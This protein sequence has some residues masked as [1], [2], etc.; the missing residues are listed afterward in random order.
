MPSATLQGL[1]RNWDDSR[2]CCVVQKKQEG[3]FKSSLSW[4]NCRTG[5]FH[6][7]VVQVAG[8]GWSITTMD[9]QLNRQ[10]RHHIIL[11]PTQPSS[12]WNNENTDHY[13]KLK[14]TPLIQWGLW[15]EVVPWRVECVGSSLVGVEKWLGGFFQT[16]TSVFHRVRAMW[17]PNSHSFYPWCWILRKDFKEGQKLIS[18][19]LL[20]PAY[21]FI[22]GRIALPPPFV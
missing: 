18:R 21:S 3:L 5:H 20:G 6:F 10:D 4:Q 19:W 13:N 2:G 17:V 11:P 1:F 15:N 12:R 16:T 14:P 7:R 8:I 9:S 22:I